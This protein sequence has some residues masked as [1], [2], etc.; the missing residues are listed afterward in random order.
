MGYFQGLEP[1]LVR[2][3]TL[4]ADNVIVSA[5]QMADFLSYVQSS[6]NW[7]SVVIRASMHKNDGMLV[8]YKIA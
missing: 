2:G 8:A 3:A 1:K 7:D 4:V 6:P 5:R